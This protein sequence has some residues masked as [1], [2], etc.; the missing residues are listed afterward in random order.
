MPLKGWGE[1]DEDY[2]KS[3]PEKFLE[4]ASIAY[5]NLREAKYGFGRADVKRVSINRVIRGGPVDRE[6]RVLH[7]KDK[8]L[9]P[10]AT[11]FNYSCHG[12][13]I[14][15]RT[16]DGFYVSSDWP[17]YAMRFVEKNGGGHAYFLQGTC[18]DINPLVTWHMRGFDAAE[19][20]GRKVANGVLRVLSEIE[21]KDCKELMIE[22]KIFKL[23]FQKM[24]MKKI[25]DDL[26]EFLDQLEV[27]EKA[28]IEELRP[29]IRFYREYAID[30]IE[31]MEKGFPDGLESRIQVCLLYTSPSPRD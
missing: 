23:P 30:M 9:K 2:V 25:V 8:D 11:L 16:D 24:T 27:R 6:V 18:G 4:S 15:V 7:F 5:N 21:V 1:I 29:S 17:G 14:D 22:K 20:T 12:V 31:K 10:L 26:I 3:L 19:E 13:A 28:S